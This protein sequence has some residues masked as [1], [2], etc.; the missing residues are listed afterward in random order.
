MKGDKT[1]WA[2]VV[3]KGLDFCQDA[4]ARRK[5]DFT[6][7]EFKAATG[8]SKTMASVMLCSVPGR[9]VMNMVVH[10]VNGFLKAYRPIR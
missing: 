5:W 9:R 6:K 2:D 7:S 3:K 4:K 10:D 1:R 8:A